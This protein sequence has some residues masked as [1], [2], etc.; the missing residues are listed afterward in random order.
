MTLERNVSGEAL[1]DIK[2]GLLR[3]G[4]RAVAII[5]TAMPELDE[6]ICLHA[7]HLLFSL[8]AGH[9]PMSNPSGELRTLLEEPQFVGFNHD[10]EG[11]LR[12]ALVTVFAGIASP[13]R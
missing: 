12:D 2:T 13:D 1:R 6:D 10:F 11:F 5:K 8:V 9:W 4:Q 3:E 7:V